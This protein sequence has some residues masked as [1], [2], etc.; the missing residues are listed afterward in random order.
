ME[1]REE[2]CGGPLGAGLGTLTS[3]RKWSVQYTSRL[4]GD[5]LVFQNISV[6]FSFENMLLSNTVILDCHVSTIDVV[7]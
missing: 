3:A 4:P 2:C 5:S 6:F 7:E 1:G